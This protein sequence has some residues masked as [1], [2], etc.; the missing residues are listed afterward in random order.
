MI[1]RPKTKKLNWD[2]VKS[3]L[4]GALGYAGYGYY[5][6]HRY[7]TGISGYFDKIMDMKISKQM[8]MQYEGRKEAKEAI[9]RGFEK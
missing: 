8:E 1:T 9:L 6:H 4:G 5:N 7:S 3:V 2:L